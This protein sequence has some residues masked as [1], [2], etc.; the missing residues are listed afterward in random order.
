[1]GPQNFFELNVWRAAHSS[2]RPLLAAAYHHDLVALHDTAPL[3][4]H[5]SLD[6]V[7]PFHVFACA[8]GWPGGL[9]RARRAFEALRQIEQDHGY[10]WL[11]APDAYSWAPASYAAWRSHAGTL[12]VLLE[13]GAA[14][15]PPTAVLPFDCAMASWFQHS[16]SGADVCARLLLMP[17][18]DPARGGKVDFQGPGPRQSYLSLALL[19]G[20]L[21]WAALLWNKQDVFRSEQELVFTLEDAPLDSLAWLETQGIDVASRLGPEHPH[22]TALKHLH[23]H[24]MNHRLRTAVDETAAAGTHAGVEEGETPETEDETEGRRRM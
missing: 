12:D 24:L 2:H 17:G 23:A 11:N 13:G 15:H 8:G 20:D 3:A 16:Q 10:D 14:V 19:R 4:A 6:L 1:M 21:D 5:W 9:M 18:A 22:S 7:N